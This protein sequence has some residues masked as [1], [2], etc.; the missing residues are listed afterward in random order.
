MGKRATTKAAPRS[1]AKKSKVDKDFNSVSDAVMDAEQVPERVRTMLVEMLPFSLKFASDE[2]HEL[3]AMAVDM[4]E[5]T[6]SGKKAALEAT[7]SSEDASLNALKASES[8]LGANVTQAE[9]AL[10]SQ[11]EVVESKKT[12]LSE[13]TTAENDSAKALSEKQK[14][15]KAGAEKSTQM[16]TDKSEMEEA[17]TEHVKPIEEGEDGKKHFKKLEPFLKSIE[18]E[19]T[20]LTALPSTC[21]KPK[22][23]RGSFD[24]LVLQELDK[25]FKLKISNLADSITAE[26]PASAQRDAAVEAAEKDHAAKKGAR[27]HAAEEFKSAEKELCDRESA[28]AKAKTEVD[29]FKPKLE[30]RTAALSAAQ[31]ALADFEAGPFTN[32]NTFKTKVAAVPEEPAAEEPTAEGAGETGAE[33]ASEQA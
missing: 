29:D 3:Q 22:D 12:T 31:V 30:E 23:K 27:E 28:L 13:A 18:I 26:G 8:Q 21:S 17:I 9:A 14:E 19:S 10:A 24:V 2:R 25:A 1:P 33:A 7:V 32:F 6:L 15:Q 4:V 16:Q 5:Q 20:L 11:R